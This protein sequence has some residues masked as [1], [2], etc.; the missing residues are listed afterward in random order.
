MQLVRCSRAVI[1]LE[2]ARQLKMERVCVLYG[3]IGATFHSNLVRKNYA[4][5]PAV[6]KGCEKLI[7]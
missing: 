5:K 1:H 6:S 3:N 7:Y 2:S 4:T